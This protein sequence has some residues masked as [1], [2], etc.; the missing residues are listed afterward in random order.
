MMLAAA[1]SSC[2]IQAMPTGE[3]GGCRPPVPGHADHLFR[4]QG[5]RF[6]GDTGISGRRGPESS[7]A[8]LIE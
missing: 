2:V 5:V 4:R 7:G 8:Y 3:S 6:F 1:A